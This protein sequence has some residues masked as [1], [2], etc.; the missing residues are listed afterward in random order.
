[1]KL[2]WKWTS[3]SCIFQSFCLDNANIL[4]YFSQFAQN[5]SDV[6][7][8]RLF[9]VWNFILSCIWFRDLSKK[10]Q[11][12]NLCECF[13]CHMCKTISR[14]YLQNVT[15]FQKFMNWKFVIIKKFV[16]YMTQIFTCLKFCYIF[17]AIKMLYALK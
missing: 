7:I 12:F 14:V 6:F 4:V 1:M 13:Y 2:H 9:L 5:R 3:S 17:S 11:N 8:K 10:L 15:K 16:T